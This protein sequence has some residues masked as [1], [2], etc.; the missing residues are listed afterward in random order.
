MQEPMDMKGRKTLILPG[1]IRTY[2]KEE[3]VFKRVLE[4]QEK[5]KN[6]VVLGLLFRAMTEL[7][8]L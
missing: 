8:A 7:L 2:F 1:I 4:R 5:F 3:V 6:M